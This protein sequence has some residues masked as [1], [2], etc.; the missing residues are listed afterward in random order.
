MYRFELSCRADGHSVMLSPAIFRT[1]REALIEAEREAYALSETGQAQCDTWA[2]PG[3][4]NG[5]AAADM[6][7]HDYALMERWAAEHEQVMS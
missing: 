3:N 5:A 7:A 6:D 1:E 4:P 2:Y